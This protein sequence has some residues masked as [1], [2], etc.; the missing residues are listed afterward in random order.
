MVSGRTS[1]VATVMSLLSARTDIG[2]SAWSW[3]DSVVP[4]ARAVVNG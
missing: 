3:M 4:G 2:R 1:K